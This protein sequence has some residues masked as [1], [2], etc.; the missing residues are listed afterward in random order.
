VPA[1]LVRVDNRLLH[2]QVIEAWIPR[3]RVRLV[4]V[5][6][7]E[8]AADPQIVDALGP[9]MGRSV[10]ISAVDPDRLTEPD[11]AA[12]VSA[13]PSLVLFRDVPTAA[14]A[15]DRGFRFTSLNIAN[16]HAGPGRRAVHPGVHLDDTDRA[17]LASLAARGVALDLR[18][19]PSDRPADPR[20]LLAPPP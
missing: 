10:A 19:V 2:G 15:F 1:E 11:L 18:A 8:S 13:L 7:R 14:R 9:L 20:R 6:D 17:L 3:L 12:K 16:V 4:V 5:A